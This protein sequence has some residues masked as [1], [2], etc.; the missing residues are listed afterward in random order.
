MVSRPNK[1]WEKFQWLEPMDSLVFSAWVFFFAWDSCDLLGVSTRHWSLSWFSLQEAPWWFEPRAPVIR[2]V[3]SQVFWTSENPPVFK[4]LISWNICKYNLIVYMLATHHDLS[5]TGRKI[6][7]ADY[8]GMMKHSKSVMACRSHKKF[9]QVGFSH[10]E[11][12][13]DRSPTDSPSPG[14]TA[15]VT[16]HPMAP[17]GFERQVT[18]SARLWYSLQLE[19]V[20]KHWWNSMSCLEDNKTWF[21]DQTWR[22]ANEWQ[23]NTMQLLHC[24]HIPDSWD[25][26][27]LDFKRLKQPTIVNIKYVGHQKAHTPPRRWGGLVPSQVR[28]GPHRLRFWASSFQRRSFLWATT[29]TEI[30]KHSDT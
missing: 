30:M 3:R 12:R 11:C 19:L 14:M 7:P 10:R 23:S 22:K 8:F 17:I 1:E 27:F 9:L 25:P 6:L 28:P 4:S 20:A 24:S 16:F 29:S 18:A 2:F 15:R 13:Q 5:N 26:D 21:S